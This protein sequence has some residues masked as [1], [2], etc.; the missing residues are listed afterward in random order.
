[1]MYIC[2]TCSRICKRPS[3]IDITLDFSF[4]PTIIYSFAVLYSIHVFPC[5]LHTLTPFSPISANTFTMRLSLALVVMLSC[6]S[7]ASFSPGF[8]VC[9]RIAATTL[10]AKS[11]AAAETIAKARKA[12]G[13]PVEEEAPALF[14]DEL[15]ED[16]RTSLLLLEKRVKEGPGSLSCDDV[17]HFQAA[18]DRISTDMKVKAAPLSHRANPGERVAEL[19]ANPPP[20]VELVYEDAGSPPPGVVVVESPPVTT[21]TTTTT[22]VVLDT[23]NDE[24]P[25]YTGK[26]GMGLASGTTNTYV[27]DGMDE[28]SPEEYQ[29]ALQD[30]ISG[31]QRNRRQSGI[32]GNRAT[33]NYLNQLNG[34]Q[35]AS[36]LKY[37]SETP[38][39]I[40]QEGFQM[41]EE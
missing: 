20:G 23:A 32:Y 3:A 16:M 7:V 15:L 33:W 8:G 10:S 12:A 14:S 17:D 30:S 39:N 4:S 11:S 2:E 31:R 37:G 36:I 13:L 34:D 29:K 18:M 38:L 27:I 35:H 26:G 6:S 40:P 1:M 25:A 28:M 21:T 24:A 41:P 22:N 9:H 19:T 5:T